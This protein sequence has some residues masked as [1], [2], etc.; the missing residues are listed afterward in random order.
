[1]IEQHKQAIKEVNQSFLDKK[2]ED[3]L[4]HCT[5]DIEWTLVGH[6]SWKGKESVR[7]TLDKMVHDMPEWPQFTVDAIIAEGNQAACHGKMEHDKKDGGKFRAQYCDLYKF[8]DGKISDMH[9]FFMEIKEK[10]VS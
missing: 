2:P 6:G 8:R 5:D 4:K 10:D 9:S 1:M 7:Q 3:F